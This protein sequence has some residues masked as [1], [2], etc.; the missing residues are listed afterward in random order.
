[1]KLKNCYSL[2]LQNCRNIRSLE[3]SPLVIARNSLNIFFGSNGT[4]KTT[5]CKAL[6]HAVLDDVEGAT[7]L[8]PFAFREANNFALKPEAKVFPKP[9]NLCFF[10][11]EWIQDHCF[12]SSSI[13]ENAF[14][15][16]V[17]NKEIRKQE[18]KRDAYIVALRHALDSD[19][20][21]KTEKILSSLQSNLGKTNKDGAFTAAAPIIKAYKN[22][23][24]LEPLPQFLHPVVKGL[25]DA[26]KALWLKWRTEPHGSTPTDICP[27]CGT[28]DPERIKDC[29]EYDT[30]RSNDAIKQWEK[31]A[32]A[33]HEHREI[34]SRPCAHLLREII[35][36][37]KAPD[38]LQL[39]QLA[40]MEIKVKETLEAINMIREA[41][42]KPQNIEAAELISELEPC[43]ITLSSC[44]LFLKT[45]KGST[46]I[47]E[48]ALKGVINAINK[49]VAAQ[50]DLNKDS[51]KLIAQVASSIEGH[52]EEINRFL[53]QC[54]Y[55]YEIKIECNIQSSEAQI[56]LVP[57]G[58]SKSVTNPK[59]ALSYGEQN[60]LS[61]ILFMHEAIKAP[62]GLIVL[63]DPISSFD[64]DKRYGVLYALFSSHRTVFSE[65]L[66]RKTVV[67]ATHDPLVVR[68]LLTIKIPGRRNRSTKGL[69][70][71]IN[72]KGQLCSKELR[73]DS[74][75]PYTQLLRKEIERCKDRPRIFGYVRVRQYCELLRKNSLERRTRYAWTFA[76]L[77]SIIHG[78]DR[79]ATMKDLGWADEHKR[80][81]EMCENLVKDLTGWKIDFW[82]EVKF[83][84]DC[85]GH[86]IG[87]YDEP[88]LSSHDKLL[89]VR[90][91]L[92]R[93]ASLADSTNII[94]R[95]ADEECHIG[96]SYLYQLDE[97][98][99]DQVPFYVVDWCDAVV[100]KAKTTIGANHQ[101]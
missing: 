32:S 59:E 100:A 60:A 91:M 11:D 42:Q 68:D 27:Y 64:Y 97:Q 85:M 43:A 87:L 84:A 86:L 6:E 7:D 95:F 58:A 25:V 14:E 48:K 47:P 79:D 69:F 80:D 54:G 57:I 40:S 34:L 29:F 99:F 73:N 3:S 92:K 2:E 12:V 16:Y 75:A 22:G 78:K 49:I 93:D 51:K 61:L 10:N 98:E 15:L 46:T 35:I 4:G 18:K 83:Y 74:M 19:E 33:Y 24:P 28:R 52:V 5:L 71:S 41:L 26:D 30:S 66:N 77:S 65:N 38:A 8:E 96:G 67:V 1:M 39:E 63:D 36:S 82:D 89:L 94:K 53:T 21:M 45:K 76:L 81:V 17:R 101:D 9:K 62:D 90:L 20:M 31:V 72:K 23:S 44:N 13:H 37:N 55:N 50:A 88:D 70:L 56:F